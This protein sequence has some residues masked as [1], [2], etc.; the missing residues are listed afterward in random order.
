MGF[1]YLADGHTWKNSGIYYALMEQHLTAS[2]N[3]YARRLWLFFNQISNQIV[4]FTRRTIFK[5]SVAKT[6]SPKW[7]G[8]SSLHC[9]I[10][11]NFRS[12]PWREL[13]TMNA[14]EI[15]NYHSHSSITVPWHIVLKRD[16]AYTRF[17]LLVSAQNLACYLHLII[18]SLTVQ[19]FVCSIHEQRHCKNASDSFL[20][21]LRFL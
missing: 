11:V 3:T 4:L 15:L 5:G 16:F 10:E 21:G 7:V 12:F 6:L 13:Y 2:H 8:V 9:F 19:P 18:Q 17:N 20:D 14:S 1:S